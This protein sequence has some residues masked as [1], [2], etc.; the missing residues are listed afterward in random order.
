MTG[1]SLSNVALRV[2]DMRDLLDNTEANS[3]DAFVTDPPYDLGFM[4][5]A[6]D[7]TGVA[8]Q[9][10]T[11]AS[12]L[13]V[14][15]PGA[16][17]VA[18][19]GT[20]TY[21]RLTCAIEDA[22]WEIRDCLSWLYGSG[23]PKSM[24]V[25]KAIDKALGAKREVVGSWKGRT[26]ASVQP[27]GGSVMSDDNCQWPGTFDIPAPA[28]DAAKQWQGWGT[29]LKPA[30]EPIILARKPLTGTVAKTVQAYGTGALN[31]DASRIPHAEG[32]MGS[33]GNGARPGGFGDVGA[34]KGN[35]V[36]CGAFNEAGRW[37]ANLLLDEAAAAL[38]GD[39][40]R[41]FYCAKAN[42]TERDAG[43]SE[44]N[45]HPTVKPLALMRW[46]CRLVTPPGGTIID[47]FCGSGST[48]CAAV[49]EGFR[50]MGFDLSAEYI[51]IAQ[52]RIAFWNNHRVPMQE[53]A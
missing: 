2:G 34:D 28:T 18:F 49:Q 42:R 35:G 51:E 45:G 25:S 32:D 7:R 14:A 16:H 21:H 3:A 48:G 44:R 24:D 12:A 36:P 9:P 46:L 47:P 39:Q 29:A 6:W 52:A 17:L 33:W 53:A 27:N 20:R 50:F 5:K 22:G 41:F 11:W 43:L 15:K 40:A 1:H 38:L 23:F 8:F 4:G 30:W 19:G 37:P 26:G 31:I 10:E 13:R